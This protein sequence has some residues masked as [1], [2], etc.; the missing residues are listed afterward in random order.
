MNKAI[1]IETGPMYGYPDTLKMNLILTHPTA[2]FL[3]DM[4]AGALA[5]SYGG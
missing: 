3:G 4:V 1:Y 5:A 2:V